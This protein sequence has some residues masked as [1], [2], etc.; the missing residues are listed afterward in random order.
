MNVRL[1]PTAGEQFISS[2]KSGNGVKRG[3]EER[4]LHME[5]LVKENGLYPNQHFLVKQ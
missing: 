1:L 2:P 4:E 5:T 3:H